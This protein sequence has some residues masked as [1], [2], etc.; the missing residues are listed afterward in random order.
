MR[1]ASALLALASVV[2]S[3]GC[4]N[5]ADSDRTNGGTGPLYLVAT[6][7]SAGDQT[8]TYLVTTP[9]FD[10]STRIDPT[11]GPKLLG[12][13]VPVVRNGAVFLP[14]SNGPVLI[15]YDLGSNDRLVKGAELSFS[16]VGMTEIMSWHVY[17]LSDTKGYVFDPRGSRI[18]VWNPSTM[19]LTGKQI[20]LAAVARDGWTPNLV[21]EHSGPRLRGKNL[22]IPLSWQ[23]QDGTSRFASGVV[24]LDTA[25]DTVVSVDEDERCGESYAT[26]ESPAGDVYFFPPDW[27]STPH[28]FADMHRPTCVARVRSGATTF[29]GGE[30][31]DLSAL[32]SGSAAAGAVPDGATGFFFTVVDQALWDD[33]NNAG[34][35]AWRFWHYDFK[36]EESRRLDSMPAWAGQGYYVNVG[37][38]FF[39]PYWRQ[40]STGSQTTLYRVNGADEPSALFSF[41]ASWYGLARLR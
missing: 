1:P 27:S 34:G 4:R 7:F 5:D 15:R 19:A 14:D 21:L 39:I 13:V 33:G 18:I 9:A 26:I 28:F 40:T 29:D 10:S 30:P 6:S 35:A 24:V 41:D 38:A 16:G 36:T 32:G 37:G 23:D 3:N 25:T 20:D 17:A 2:L 12:G 22:L 8:E 11:D 31:L